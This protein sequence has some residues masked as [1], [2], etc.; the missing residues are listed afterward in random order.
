M[1][2][3]ADIWY[4]TNGGNDA[5]KTHYNPSRY[6]ALNLHALFSR[7][8]TIEIRLRQFC[9]ENSMSWILLKSFILLCLAMDKKA[10]EASSASPK[11]QADWT[12]AYAFRC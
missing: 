12:S 8:N 1:K 3:L 2:A 5:R 7:Y 10:K 4:E 9:E 11:R 6:H